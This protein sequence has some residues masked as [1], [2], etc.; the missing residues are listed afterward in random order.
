MLDRAAFRRATRTL[1]CG[2]IS[3]RR[4]LSI[5]DVRFTRACHVARPRARPNRPSLN[6]TPHKAAKHFAPRVSFPPP[7]VSTPAVYRWY[8]L[9]LYQR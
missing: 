5:L 3:V 8:L 6:S 7:L 9:V 1:A 4:A 2:P